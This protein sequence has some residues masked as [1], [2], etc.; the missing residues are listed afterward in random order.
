MTEHAIKSAMSIAGHMC[1]MVMIWFAV[2]NTL[3]LIWIM[4]KSTNK[5]G[6][7]VNDV[8]SNNINKISSIWG[9]I[10][11]VLYIFISNPIY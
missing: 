3:D 8:I 4:I 2:S 6:D 5:Q 7:D 11:V 1:M 10:I 9:I